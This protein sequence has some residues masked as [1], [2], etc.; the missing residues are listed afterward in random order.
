MCMR[1]GM[2]KTPDRT[3]RV[4]LHQSR[5][6]SPNRTG[7]FCRQPSPT[8]GLVRHASSTLAQNAGVWSAHASGLKLVDNDVVHG[9]RRQ[10]EGAPV[11]VKAPP[12]PHDLSVS[13]LKTSTRW[14]PAG[15]S[16]RFFSGKSVE[17]TQQDC[18]CIAATQELALNSANVLASAARRNA[19]SPEPFCCTSNLKSGVHPRLAS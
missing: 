12:S 3:H 1:L 15:H 9:A 17:L 14:G 7:S 4:R 6:R 5:P 19:M 8:F 16:G 10:Q 2:F 11:E 18:T 13:K